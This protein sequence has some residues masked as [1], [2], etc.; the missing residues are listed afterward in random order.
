MHFSYAER[1][2]SFHGMATKFELKTL[3]EDF[4]LMYLRVKGEV[5]MGLLLNGIK[6]FNL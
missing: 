1:C 5:S 4:L 2:I 3:L 6:I